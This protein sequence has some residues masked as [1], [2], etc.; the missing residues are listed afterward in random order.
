MESVTVKLNKRSYPIHIAPGLLGQAGKL[1]AA[2]PVRKTVTVIT[3]TTV[4]PLYLDTLKTSLTNASFHVNDIIIPDGEQYKNLSQAE[5][6]YKKL[7]NLDLDRNSPLLALGGGVVG[8]ITGFTASTFLR[9]VPFIQ[10]PTTLL[11]QVDSSVGGK[12]GV[13]LPDGKNMVGTFYQPSIVIIDPSVIKTLDMREIRTGL[14]EVIK[15]GIIRDKNFFVFLTENITNALKLD[16]PTLIHILQTCCSIKADI[17]TIDETEKGIRSILNFGHTIGHAIETLTHY[18]TYMHGEAVSIGMAA[19]ARLS[20][21]WKLCSID[22]RD[23]VNSLLSAAGLPI[24]LPDFTCSDYY[25]VMQRDKKKSGEK[26]R[27]ILMQAI[28]TVVI[29]DLTSKEL[30]TA[31]NRE[32][33]LS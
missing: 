31:L 3:N 27:M 33:N 28:G 22:D 24:E 17:T 30:L 11:A 18:R 15:Y 8:D 32:F 10:I 5:D 12:T 25:T 6:I 20:C 29:K 21:Y 14:S 13:N 23:R 2:L 19:A 26:I 7:L 1:L 9:G 4:A 16:E